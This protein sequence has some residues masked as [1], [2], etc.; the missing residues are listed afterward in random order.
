MCKVQESCE[1]QVVRRLL[2]LGQRVAT[3][4]SCTGGGIGARLTAVSG[5]S[6]VFDGGVISYANEVKERLLGVSATDLATVGA[7]SAEVALQMAQGVKRLMRADWALSVTG[8]AGPGGATPDKPVGLVY[9][10][11]ARPDGTVSA[12]RCFFLGD[13]DEIRSQSATAA[14]GWLLAETMEGAF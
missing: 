11:L 8:L 14:L 9:I 5:A 6:G 1:A 7:V 2:E 4:E 12:R 10:G 3:A 13:R